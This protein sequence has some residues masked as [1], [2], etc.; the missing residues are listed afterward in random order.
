M[1]ELE[2]EIKFDG[3]TITPDPN[4]PSFTGPEG[5]GR[6]VYLLRCSL[7]PAIAA[8][9]PNGAKNEGVAVFATKA[10]AEKALQRM[11]ALASSVRYDITGIGLF[12]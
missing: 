7:V 4:F 8:Q 2:V 10:G 3:R 6:Y 1:S 9:Y 5:T 12:E 11:Q